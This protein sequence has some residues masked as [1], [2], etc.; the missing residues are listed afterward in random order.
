MLDMTTESREIIGRRMNGD[1]RW[2]PPSDR[3]HGSHIGRLN[4]VHDR[5][6]AEAEK[7]GIDLLFVMY[8]LRH[9]FATRMA[10]DGTDLTTLAQILGHSSIRCVKKY[11]HPAADHK[12]RAMKRY[13]R[14]MKRAKQ[15]AERILRSEDA[16]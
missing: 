3:L 2:I 13:D 12:K 15:K 9:T 5:I 14:T 11:V 1:S 8:D 16:A 10:I 4:S 6:M 7:D